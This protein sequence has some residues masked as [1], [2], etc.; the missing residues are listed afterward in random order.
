M[1]YNNHPASKNPGRK[2]R[3]KGYC[4]VSFCGGIFLAVRRMSGQN[5]KPDVAEKMQAQGCV[6]KAF[7]HMTLRRC[8]SRFFFGRQAGKPYL[9]RRGNA[10]C[11][12]PSETFRPKTERASASYQQA[13]TGGEVLRMLSMA[14]CISETPSGQR[15]LREADV[16]SACLTELLP[17][18]A[19]LNAYML[20][21]TVEC[22]PDYPPSY[23]NR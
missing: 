4:S 9:K 5:K 19:R 18:D 8:H 17:G 20:V 7:P 21:N 10:P 16:A 23:G 11:T 12:A 3:K 14:I 6:F 2:G 13:M 15:D 1:C 22:V